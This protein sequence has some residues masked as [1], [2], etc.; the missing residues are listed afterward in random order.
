MLA[1]LASTQ[2]SPVG[3]RPSRRT[4]PVD[5]GDMRPVTCSQ[6]LQI[7]SVLLIYFLIG[8]IIAGTLY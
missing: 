5:D 3:P 1:E 8:E 6:V 2:T 7:Q 4:G